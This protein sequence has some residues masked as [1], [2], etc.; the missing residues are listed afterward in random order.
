[1]KNNWNVDVAVLLIFFTRHDT[2]EKAFEAVRKA[3]PSKLLLWQDGPREGREDDVE[4]IEKCRKIAENIDWDCEVHRFYNEKNHGCDPSTFYAQKWAF[5][6][7]D[8][9]IILEDDMVAEESFFRYCKELLDKYENDER[10]NHICGVNNLGIFE[11]CPNDYLFA[12]NGTGAWASWRRV[13][14]EWDE[15]YGFLDNEYAV[16]N[17]KHRAPK[18][19]DATIKTAYNRRAAGK[20]YWE[21]ILGMN[22]MLNNRLVIISKK[23]L[24]TNIGLI[25]NSTH[26]ANPKLL[27]KSVKAIFNAPS[28]VQEFPL[29]HPQYVVADEKYYKECLKLSGMSNPFIPLWRKIVY[30]FNCLRYG[31]ATRILYAIKKKFTKG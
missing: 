12:Y 8:K 28:Y 4:N 7:C 25:E 31:E 6:I 21:S 16:K 18:L 26:G 20:A 2:F 5:S 15:N 24:V 10:I 9:C 3:R 11:Q 17:I 30:A 23:N 13:A 1:M 14:E 22:A 27:P 29:K 19:T